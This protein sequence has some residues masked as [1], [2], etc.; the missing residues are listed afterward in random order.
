MRVMV[1]K[2]II[3]L[4]GSAL[5]AALLL[6]N[7]LC[8]A[9]PEEIQ[10]YLDDKEDPGVMSIDWHNN[11]VF[12]GRTR[13]DYVGEKPPNHLYRLTPELNYGVSQVFELGA[14]LLTS[15]DS[16]GQWAAD[17]AKV[18]LKYIAPHMEEGVFYGLNLEVGQ[19]NHAL[20]QDPWGAQLKGILGWR[21]GAWTL[22]YNMNLDTALSPRGGPVTSESDLKINYAVTHRTQMGIESYNELGPSSHPH[23]FNADSKVLY[24]VLDTSFHALDINMGVGRGL[25]HPSDMWTLKMIIGTHFQ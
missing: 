4:A 20:S 24:A 15:R 16:S 3:P 2:T 12:S 5:A 14:Y 18:R 7:S 17:G 6:C 25:T 1:C 22:G 21:H 8:I 19:Q 11:Y 23:A 9:A 13:P 10:V